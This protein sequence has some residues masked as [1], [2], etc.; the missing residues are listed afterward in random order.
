MKMKAAVLNEVNAPLVVE[1]L[2]LMEPQAG[3]VL[4]KYAASGVCHSDLHVIDG[5]LPYDLPVVL[6]HEGAGV[7]EATGPGVTRVT[8]GDH[9]ITA[10]ILTCGSCRFCATGRPNL[11]MLRYQARNVMLDGTHRLHRN[12]QPI[13]H[14]LQVSSYAQFA[15]L[16]QES[17]VLIRKDAPLDKVCLIG[18]GVT[19]G[20][21]AVFNRARVEPGS[22]V[23]VF[24]C[25]G[26]G[27]NVV[28]G[29]AIA[30]AGRIIAVDL[31]KNKLAMAEGMGATHVIDA[32]SEDSVARIQE[33]TG[34]MGADYSFEV[35]GSPATI[36]QAFSSVHA[37]GT[38]VVIGVSPA[39]A[40]V[41][42]PT[43]M[44]SPERT[45]MG[46]SFG[47]ARQ[48]ADLPML[49][50]MYMDGKLKL[51]ELISQTMPLE[52]INTAFDLLQ[53]GEVARTVI[54]YGE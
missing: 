28:Q 9:I 32:S 51:D 15:V 19:A 2:E 39:G 8:E 27:L 43:S 10:Y 47:G 40:E 45:L 23:A 34:G 4:V 16:P 31:L 38:C 41:T 7:V 36:Q 50:D 35:I 14:F 30:G 20:A 48:M 49:V 11:C 42:L 29:A 24:G 6:G 18:C 26:V 21:G 3:E 53:K 46:A 12:G 54:V 44:I 33:L 25:G 17:V 52:D 22:S 1:D 13:N 5:V 37:G